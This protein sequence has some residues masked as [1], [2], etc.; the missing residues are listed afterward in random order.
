MTGHYSRQ[1]QQKNCGLLLNSKQ[2]VWQELKTQ[3]TP[4]LET[5][6]DLSTHHFLEFS[7]LIC[8]TFDIECLQKK[9]QE[10]SFISVK[11]IHSDA[12]KLQ[13]I[14]SPNTFKTRP[15]DKQ[16]L[17]HNAVN[18]MML[19]SSPLTSWASILYSSSLV[20]EILSLSVLSTTTI[21]NYKKII[22]NRSGESEQQK[23]WS[24][25][26]HVLNQS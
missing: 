5:R 23:L 21:T 10:S 9:M 19:L 1:Q 14:P 3:T 26:R 2:E 13:I 12:N 24:S 15:L 8:L 20:T 6:Q 17:R 18:Y 25:A 7:T 16:E 4:L 22:G 11:A